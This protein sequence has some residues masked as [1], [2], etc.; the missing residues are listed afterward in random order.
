MW[1]KDWSGF[2]RVGGVLALANNSR[3]YICPKCYQIARSTAARPFLVCGYCNIA[4]HHVPPQD[5]S[6]LEL[7]PESSLEDLNRGLD[8]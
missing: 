6:R 1:P 2:V 5:V 4:M 7:P 3:K 8:K